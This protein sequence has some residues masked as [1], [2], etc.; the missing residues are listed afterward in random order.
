M[1]MDKS[2]YQSKTIWGSILVVVG[3]VYGYLTEDAAGGTA[4]ATI[5][6]GLLGVGLRTAMK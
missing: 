3:A 1:I 4:I 6:I 2:W 5:G